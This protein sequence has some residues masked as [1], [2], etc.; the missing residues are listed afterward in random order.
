MVLLLLLPVAI[1]HSLSAVWIQLPADSSLVSL[2]TPSLHSSLSRVG[3][4]GT[5]GE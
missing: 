1:S 5:E 2:F 3:E 4:D